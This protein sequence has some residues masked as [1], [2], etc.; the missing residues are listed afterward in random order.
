MKEYSEIDVE[1]FEPASTAGLH[2]KVHIRPLPGQYP[3]LPEMHVS[4]SKELTEKTAI[5]PVASKFR[6]LAKITSRNGG[7]KYI[8]TH[9]KWRVIELS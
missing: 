3:Y 1:S 8:Y 6:I 2:G 9:P 5:Y 7:K 4:C